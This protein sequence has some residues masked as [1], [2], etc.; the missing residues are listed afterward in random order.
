MDS[1][2]NS[3]KSEDFEAKKS[4]E[5]SQTSQSAKSIRV[6]TSDSRKNETYKTI[7]K[8][9]DLEENDSKASLKNRYKKIQEKSL[10]MSLVSSDESIHEIEERD[11]KMQLINSN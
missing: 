5:N 10:D 2:S 4:E 11:S 1:Q 6:K 3:D 9:D 7:Q 8:V